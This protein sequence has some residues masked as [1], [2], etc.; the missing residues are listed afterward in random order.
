MTTAERLYRSLKQDITTCAL[1]PGQPFS[2][3]EICRRYKASRTPAREACQHLQREGLVTIVPFRGY[4]VAPLTLAE[5]HNL[6]EVQLIVDPAAAGLAA[7]RAQPAQLKAMEQWA[8][9][10]YRVGVRASYV[11][12]LQ[13]NFNLHVGIAQASHNQHLVE[14]ATTV[15][16]RLM[17]FFYLIIAMDAYGPQL[18]QEHEQIVAAIRARQPEQARQRAAEHV[19][20]TIRRSAGLFM[21]ST[22]A[23]LGELIAEPGSLMPGF[24]GEALADAAGVL[25]PRGEH[26]DAARFHTAREQIEVNPALTAKAGRRRQEA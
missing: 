3:A 22:E 12:F 23:R 20:H 25:A 5:F 18:V 16:T 9:Y 26:G 21:T 17:R 13:R 10:E 8:E 15:Q 14:I 19:T 2:E 6:H 4:F 1:R 24:G 7:L 11:T